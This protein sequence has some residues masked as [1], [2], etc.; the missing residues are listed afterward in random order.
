MGPDSHVLAVDRSAKAIALLTPAAADLIALE[1][2]VRALVP[3]GRVFLDGD[4]PLREL[5][6]PGRVTLRR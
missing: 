2:L 4:S 3:G 1:R 5:E 6:V